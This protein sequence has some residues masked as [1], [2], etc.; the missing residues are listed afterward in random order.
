MTR[1][2]PPSARIRMNNTATAEA[3]ISSSPAPEL[4]PEPVAEDPQPE[5]AVAPVTVVLEQVE[6]VVEVEVHLE[7]VVEPELE[8][9]APAP[10]EEASP[11]VLEE[12]VEEEDSPSPLEVTPELEEPVLE[13]PVVAEAPEEEE[14]PHWKKTMNKSELLEFLNDPAFTMENTKNEI[15]AA[16]EA[17]DAQAE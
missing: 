6:D 14:A 3:S 17:Q 8:P 16:L 2:L 1:Y 7:S 12:V 13:E 10:E 9:V 4:V 11:V 15:I 5:V